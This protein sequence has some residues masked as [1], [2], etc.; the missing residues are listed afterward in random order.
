MQYKGF[1]K[2]LMIKTILV[3]GAKGFIGKNLIVPLK[4][5][6]D[7]DGIEHDLD[8]PANL[9]RNDLSGHTERTG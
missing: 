2:G 5:R 9:V 1:D 7:V 6:A 3:T 4:R 8:S